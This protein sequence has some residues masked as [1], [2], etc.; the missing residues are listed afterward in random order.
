MKF[1]ISNV[2]EKLVGENKLRVHQ[3]LDKRPQTSVWAVVMFWGK[4]VQQGN[5]A[6]KMQQM[7]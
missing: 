2:F 1:N 7:V 6:I 3:P 4:A 5:K